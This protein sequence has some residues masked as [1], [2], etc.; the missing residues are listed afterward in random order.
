MSVTLRE[1]AERWTVSINSVRRW[2]KSGQLIAH[3]RVGNYGPEYVISEAEIERYEQSHAHRV[4][5]VQPDA[6]KPI[7][8]PHLKLVAENL[9]YLMKYSPKGFLLTDENHDIVDVSQVF[10][11]MS[12]CTREQLIGYKPKILASSDHLNA[13]QYPVMYKSLSQAGFWEGRF[14]N[15]RPDGELWYADSMI[16]MI[17]IGEQTVGYWAIVA[18]EEMG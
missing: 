1:A 17:R 16:T 10:L 4:T 11:T 2:V 15:R 7:L 6:Y 9:Q 12:G 18:A 5:K 14:V 3:I 13:K 8:R